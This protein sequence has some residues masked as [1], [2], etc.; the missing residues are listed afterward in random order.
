MLTIIVPEPEL[1]DEATQRFLEPEGTKLE[2]EHSLVSLSKWE[3]K[4]EK[5]FLGKEEKTSEEI[6]DYVR[7]MVLTPDVS[8][9]VFSKLTAENNEAISDYI[10]AKMTA[11]WFIDNPDSKPSTQTITNELV[12]YWLVAH[13]IEWE[14]QYWHLNRLLT[15]IRV[16][17]EQNKQNDPNKKKQ[18]ARVLA[19]KYRRLN[20]ERKAKMKTRG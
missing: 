16:C 9:D 10:A 13:Q 6:L 15:L 11:T 14:A 2:L 19:D 7:C 20:A 3:S 18:N 17:N 4:W 8:P 12:Y 1:F 5:P